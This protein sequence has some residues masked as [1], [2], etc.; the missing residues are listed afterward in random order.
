MYEAV[1]IPF[2]VATATELKEIGFY[3]GVNDLNIPSAVNFQLGVYSRGAA[4]ATLVYNMEFSWGVF[5]NTS[6]WSAQWYAKPVSEISLPPGDYLLTGTYGTC[7]TTDPGVFFL[8]IGSPTCTAYRT[9]STYSFLSRGCGVFS[10]TWNWL[11]GE[12]LG[13]GSNPYYSSAW[14]SSACYQMYATTAP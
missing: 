11:L 14:N 4:T 8:G 10:G 12:G 13:G 9:T 7:H 2:T 3:A 1:S 6:V 5:T